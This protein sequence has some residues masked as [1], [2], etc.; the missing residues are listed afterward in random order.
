MRMAQ[1]HGPKTH[2]REEKRGRQHR[3]WHFQRT[4]G[5][6]FGLGDI[7]PTIHPTHSRIMTSPMGHRS[8]H[9]IYHRMEDDHK[10][11][12]K[13]KLRFTIAED[14]ATVQ[15]NETTVQWKRDRDDRGEMM[16]RGDRGH[17][18]CF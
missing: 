8:F 5:S 17:G 1:A 3:S 6:S 7:T 16:V 12:F 13:N 10:T 2:T 18:A 9:G 15:W 11:R 14:G 4:L